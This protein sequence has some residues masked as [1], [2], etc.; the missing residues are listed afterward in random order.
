MTEERKDRTG[1]DG[2]RKFTNET[3][4]ALVDRDHVRSASFQHTGQYLERGR[5]SIYVYWVSERLHTCAFFPGWPQMRCCNQAGPSIR[6]RGEEGVQP[7]FLL[8]SSE[9]NILT[10]SGTSTAFLA[11]SAKL[12]SQNRNPV[13]FW[14]LLQSHL[15]VGVAV[16][17][18]SRF[19][20]CT[21]ACL[22]ASNSCL[23]I[24]LP[25]RIKGS[26]SQAGFYRRSPLHMGN[27]QL[28]TGDRVGT[29]SKCIRI[30]VFYWLCT[31]ISFDLKNMIQ[32]FPW[33]LSCK[34]RN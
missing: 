13:P 34:E 20:V 27:Q 12:I 17:I 19:S 29:G 15:L 18:T 22:Q 23:N 32:E 24:W 31:C 1:G 30:I 33:W 25:Q 14:G 3:S 7:N 16:K 9:V 28:S 2:V 6:K 21:V 26:S 11:V 8:V 5:P 4:R 10:I